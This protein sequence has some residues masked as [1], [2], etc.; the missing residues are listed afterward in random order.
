[1]VI[2][3]EDGSMKREVT[4]EELDAILHKLRL[5]RARPRMRGKTD[6]TVGE[7]YQTVLPAPVW[8]VPELLPAGLASLAG[9]P[10]MGK[11]L[12]ALQLAAAV[13]LGRTFLG[14][15][16]KAGPVLF[17][18][19]E[20]SPQR[21]QERVQRLQMTES[22]PIQ[23]YTEWAALDRGGGLWELQECMADM[24][25]RLVVID[26]LNRALGPGGASRSEQ[27]SAALTAL[28]RLAHERNCC[29]LTVDHHRKGGQARD[30]VNDLLGPTSKAAALDTVWGL[31]SSGDQGG[32]SLRP[33]QS[34]AR[35]RVTG[36]EVRRCELALEFDAG[37]GMW[38]LG[39]EPVVAPKETAMVDVGRALAE[40]GGVATTSEIAS[41]LGMH[42]GNVSRALARLVAAGRVRRLPREGHRVPYQWVG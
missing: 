13:A 40:L 10:K 12:L 19:L 9:R 16:V 15:K 37:S 27:V 17:L 4:E 11:S 39:A 32:V 36:R 24:P 41:A 18:A 8:I 14:Y 31:Y 6:W 35:L 20:D 23:F 1:M 2:R 5:V 25:P 7:L 21:L 42:V 3:N 38:Q 34:T 29:V 26:T 33:R 28:Q 30:V 22:A